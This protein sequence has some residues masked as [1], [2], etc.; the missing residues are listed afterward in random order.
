MRKHKLLS[1][2][3][4]TLAFTVF[5]AQAEKIPLS[6]VPQAVINSLKERHPDAKIIKVEEEH[7][8]A[9]KLYEVKFKLDGKKQEL[10]YTPQGEYFGFEEDI[11][12]SELPEA[13]I[14]SLKQTFHKLSIEKAEKIKHPDGRIEYEIDV[15]G[16]NEE[17]EMIMTSTGEIWGQE[18]D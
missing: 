8:F 15:K 12:I 17:W 18:R 13:V 14:N 9:I 7:H 10:L 4:A 3:L 6:E 16:D 5:P 1:P 11:N 2:L